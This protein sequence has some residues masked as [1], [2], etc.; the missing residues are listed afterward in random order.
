[1]DCDDMCERK[2]GCVGSCYKPR[3]ETVDE[4][5]DQNRKGLQ[6]KKK[7]GLEGWLKG[8]ESGRKPNKMET[9]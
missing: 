3:A 5:P 9:L 4:L 2:T 6:K 8:C 7:K 1:M